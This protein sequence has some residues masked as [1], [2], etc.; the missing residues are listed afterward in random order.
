MLNLSEIIPAAPF[1]SDGEQRDALTS[2]WG[3]RRPF[4]VENE[5]EISLM[6]RTYVELKMGACETSR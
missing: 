6:A 2:M 3:V 5:S 1:D 4:S